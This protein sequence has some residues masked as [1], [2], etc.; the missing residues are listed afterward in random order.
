MRAVA[1]PI[2]TKAATSARLR[3]TLSPTWPKGTAPNG[4]TTKPTAKVPNASNVPTARPDRKTYVGH[5]RPL[6]FPA[7]P[8]AH[9]LPS[10]AS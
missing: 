9:I 8:H 5:P 7:R 10:N 1:A 6:S 3:P 2:S 4:R